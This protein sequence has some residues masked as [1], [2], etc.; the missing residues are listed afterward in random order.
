[1]RDNRKNLK[2]NSKSV[3]QMRGKFYEVIDKRIAETVNFKKEIKKV[4]KEIKDLKRARRV[5]EK[6]NVDFDYIKKNTE[7]T[8][9]EGLN[10]QDDQIQKLK[11]IRYKRQQTATTTRNIEEMKT[12]RYNYMSLNKW[13]FLK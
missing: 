6:A 5:R 4:N 9:E 2:G 10:L 3:K 1:M 13:D 8:T 12:F 11:N 7:Q